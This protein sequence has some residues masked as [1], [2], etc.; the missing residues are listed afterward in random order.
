MRRNRR[1]RRWYRRD[2]YFAVNEAAVDIPRLKERFRKRFL[3]LRELYGGNIA[4]LLVFNSM[5]FRIPL[6]WK[7]IY[8]PLLMRLER[9]LEKRQ[10]KRL[11]CFVICMWRKTG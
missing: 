6:R 4:Y 2:G 5:I 8:A 3:F 10:G 1:R 7:P 9:V 11:S